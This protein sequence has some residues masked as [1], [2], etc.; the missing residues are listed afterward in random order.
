MARRWF[1]DPMTVRTSGFDHD[2]HYRLLDD[3]ATGGSLY[4]AAGGRLEGHVGGVHAGGTVVDD[5]LDPG[6]REFH[7]RPLEAMAESLL[8]GGMNWVG[9]DPRRPG[10][11]T[12]TLSVICHPA[13]HARIAGAA[14]LLL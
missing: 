10:F 11:R 7:F 3:L 8:A 1:R 5:D 9:I 12:R 2:L 13:S 6:D 14:G 4:G